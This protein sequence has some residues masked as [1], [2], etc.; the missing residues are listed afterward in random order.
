M[1]GAM[2][3]QP[4]TGPRH[5]LIVPP[6]TTGSDVSTP[7][8][9]HLTTH[10]LPCPALSCL[11]WDSSNRRQR[12]NS[13]R[14]AR[15]AESM[16]MAYSSGRPPANPTATQR[17]PQSTWQPPTRH[18]S[19]IHR[20][21]AG[22]IS[23]CLWTFSPPVS[24]SHN[25]LPPSPPPPSPPSSGPPHH[26]RDDSTASHRHAVAM[27]E[28]PPSPPRIRNSIADLG[29]RLRVRPHQHVPTATPYT[30]LC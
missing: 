18:L 17:S 10:C 15:K 7:W 2:S 19:R 8:P 4:V 25:S 6:L 24:V 23:P 3:Q 30:C 21:H 13:D 27:A 26:S 14:A 12:T 11:C 22:S 29:L 16:T 9:W 5:S 1:H 20:R 28:E